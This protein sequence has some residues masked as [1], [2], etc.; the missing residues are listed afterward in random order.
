MKKVMI[1]SAAAILATTAVAEAASTARTDQQHNA[2]WPPGEVFS[3]RGAWPSHQTIRI[4]LWPSSRSHPVG[5]HY[6]PRVYG[7]PRRRPYLSNVPTSED[8]TM[9]QNFLTQFRERKSA[10]SDEQR[11]DLE[12]AITRLRETLGIYQPRDMT[13]AYLVE[14]RAAVEAVV[15]ARDSLG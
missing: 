6:G 11:G 14:L 12:R 15:W 8:A 9:L 5:R 7:R 4:S 10:T 1:I 13:T 3:F 2:G